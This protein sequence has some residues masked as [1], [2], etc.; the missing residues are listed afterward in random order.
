MHNLT[1][2]S[3]LSRKDF[4]TTIDGKST[5]LYILTN[6]EGLEMAVCNYGAAILSLFTP[7]AR[8]DMRTSSK[9]MTRWS[10]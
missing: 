10:T 2:R 6:R 7:T 4:Q 8:D 9:D 1:N 3:E 5:D